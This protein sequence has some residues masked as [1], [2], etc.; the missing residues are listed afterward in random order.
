ML[1]KKNNVLYQKYKWVVHTYLL[2]NGNITYEQIRD[3]SNGISISTIRSALQ[4][5]FDNPNLYKSKII[6]TNPIKENQQYIFKNQNNEVV[7]I[8]DSKKVE[9]E[10]ST[11]EFWKQVYDVL[12]KKGHHYGKRRSEYKTIQF[13]RAVETVIEQRKKNKGKS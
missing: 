9:I 1:N 6:S 7:G 13:I 8:S 3:M 10:N 5:Y 2:Y 11:M 4:Y 12:H